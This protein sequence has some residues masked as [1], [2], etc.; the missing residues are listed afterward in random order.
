METCVKMRFV[1]NY[2]V[3]THC[4]SECTSGQYKAPGLVIVIAIFYRYCYRCYHS[5]YCCLLFVTISIV[6]VVIVVIVVT[7]IVIRVVVGVAHR[8]LGHPQIRQTP[9]RDYFYAIRCPSHRCL[10][11]VWARQFYSSAACCVRMCG[12]F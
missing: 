4:I 2:N 3:S 1:P 9:L 11:P 7:G 8:I 6:I 5:C 12:C 10:L